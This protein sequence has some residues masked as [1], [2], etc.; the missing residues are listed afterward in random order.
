[1]LVISARTYEVPPRTAIPA[2]AIDAA[3]SGEVVYLV[4]HG[5]RIAA[6]VPPK[7]ATAGAGAIE[8]LKRAEYLTE[9]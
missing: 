2:E 6:V 1:V 4:R 7:V 5:R 8:A 9:Q 3:A